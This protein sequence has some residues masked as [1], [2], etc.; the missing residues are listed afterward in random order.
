M[1]VPLVH[2]VETH[3]NITNHSLVTNKLYET[4]YSRYRCKNNIRSW[5]THAACNAFQCGWLIFSHSHSLFPW[6]LIVSPALKINCKLNCSAVELSI[7]SFHPFSFVL[8]NSV[9]VDWLLAILIEHT[10]MGRSILLCG[11]FS[12]VQV[13]GKNVRSKSDLKVGASKCQSPSIVPIWGCG[14]M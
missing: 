2:F 4:N 5:L 7:Y 1:A 10:W 3:K 14:W 9:M 8:F 12:E 13:F 11:P 6:H